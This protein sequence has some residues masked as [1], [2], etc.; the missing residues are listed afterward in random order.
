MINTDIKQADKLFNE[1]HDLN[2]GT[3][4]LTKYA[5]RDAFLAGFLK[6]T[7]CVSTLPKDMVIPTEETDVHD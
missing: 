4:N 5:M 6:N 1:W 7:S 2:Y 3:E